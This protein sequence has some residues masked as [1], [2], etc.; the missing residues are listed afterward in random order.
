MLLIALG[1]ILNGHPPGVAQSPGTPKFFYSSLGPPM[2][3][4][5]QVQ[6]HRPS[7]AVM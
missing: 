1:P 7:P 2:V 4:E 3:P 6:S 5:S